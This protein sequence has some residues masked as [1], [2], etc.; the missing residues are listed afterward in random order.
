[1]LAVTVAAVETS[2]A[3]E[4]PA[5]QISIRPSEPVA[6]LAGGGYEEALERFD[7][8]LIAAGLAR[9]D[10][11]VRETARLLEISRNTLRAKIKKHN[12]A[13]GEPM[14]T[15]ENPHDLSAE[16][17]R[18]LDELLA[19]AAWAGLERLSAARQLEQIKT[20]PSLRTPELFDVMI[21][22]TERLA[23]TDPRK[24]EETA[25]LAY[26]LA[27]LLPRSR[28]PGATLQDLWSRALV[29]AADCRRLAGDWQD[30]GGTLTT[31]RGHLEQGAR[32]PVHEAHLLSVQASL[33]SD[34]GQAE[35]ALALL[36][37][38]TAL[39]RRAQDTKAVAALAVQEAGILL[40]ADRFEDAVARAKEALRLLVPW[41]ARL[42][43]QARDL[44]TEGLLFLARPHEALRTYMDTES[45]HR[46]LGERRF[47]SQVSYLEALLLDGLGD[48]ETSEQRFAAPSGAS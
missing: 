9:C 35:E 22:A 3:P 24:G 17:L 31:A 38:A 23:P 16:D 10:G 41:Q 29:A 43:M 19:D 18:I 42:E 11:R 5:V 28:R 44:V 6:D 7:H 8:D 1:M 33:A 20:D 12:L 34:L 36:A 32:L 47:G 39:Y 2:P 13:P 27:G 46:D 40:A 30:A 48:A 14:P 45:L 26:T 21:T 37:Q 15:P 4:S 25:L